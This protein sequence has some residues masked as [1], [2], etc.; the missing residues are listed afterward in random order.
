MKNIEKKATSD[1]N[2]NECSKCKNEIFPVYYGNESFYQGV[3]Y[4][5]CM[6]CNQ[7]YLFPEKKAVN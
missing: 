1:V 2:L 5:R 4:K 3:I 6:I 7:I